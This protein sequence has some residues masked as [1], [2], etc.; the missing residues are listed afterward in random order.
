MGPTHKVGMSTPVGKR[1]RRPE[2]V[3]QTS[4]MIDSQFFAR[5][6]HLGGI[7][8]ISI[9]ARVTKAI[10]KRGNVPVIA[11]VNGIAEVRASLKPCG[12][13]R[14]RLQLNAAAR[15]LAQAETG[16][17]LAIGPRVHE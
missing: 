14:H 13:G 12:G 15:R 9:P 1:L 16:A 10:G 11:L 8:A 7:Y 6:E 3:L 2:P 5:L 4:R 17:R